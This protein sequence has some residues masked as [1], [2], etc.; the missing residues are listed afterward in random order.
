MTTEDRKQL[1]PMLA[2][3]R[4]LVSRKD[5]MEIAMVYIQR[6]RNYVIYRIDKETT[7]D[8]IYLAC[9]DIMYKVEGLVIISIEDEVINIKRHMSLHPEYAWCHYITYGDMDE[10]LLWMQRNG[11]DLPEKYE[12]LV[13]K[14][15]DA[16]SALRERKYGWWEK[17]DAKRDE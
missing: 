11:Q 3:L 1:E 8:S 4:S 6:D 12:D 7:A 14:I 5:F 2:P 9:Y 16:L 10:V 13:E 17:T 15:E